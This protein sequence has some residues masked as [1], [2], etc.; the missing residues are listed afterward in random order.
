MRKGTMVLL[1]AGAALLGFRAPA[2]GSGFAIYTQGAEALAQSASVIAHADGPY[3]IF[4][5]PALINRLPGT[6]VELGTTAIFP[7]RSFDSGVTG[8]S[9]DAESA[10][11]F[12]STVFITH[13]VNDRLSAGLGVF[14]PFGLGTDWGETW[15]GRY[16]ATASDLTTFTINPVA[17]VQITPFLTVAA[18][19]EVLILDAT[20][21][22][23]ILSPYPDGNQKFKGDGEALGFN[24]GLLVTPGEDISI[25]VSFR[26]QKDVDIEGDARFTVP[27]ALAPFFPNTRAKTKLKLPAQVMAGIHYKGLYPI[28][29]EAGMR[30]EGWSSFDE[31]R[32]TLDQ[33]IGPP[34]GTAVS[35][36]PRDWHDAFSGNLGVAYHVGENLTLMGGYLFSGNPIPDKTFEPAIPDS[37]THLFS[38]GAT[39]RRGALRL[40]LA[41]A[42]QL[43][44]ER[45]KN[46]A[47]DDN[48]ADGVLNLATS[49]N[50]EYDSHLHMVALSVSYRF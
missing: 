5:N 38:L 35:V 27:A 47:I 8:D 4:Y 49:A 22:K 43:L 7:S 46:N 50:G 28:T 9:T 14:N 20:L 12:P 33:P 17:S 15:G 2:M 34:P 1:L 31:L 19:L 26:S 11:F 32:V 3:A 41:Y 25:G 16:I 21:E 44:E 30:W 13:K 40:S 6:Q 36:S 10:V 18:G 23:K 45:T 48:P 24:L 42:F 37:D 29:F 39:A